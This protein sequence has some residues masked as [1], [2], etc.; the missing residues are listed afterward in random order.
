MA[1][2]P[3]GPFVRFVITTSAAV[4]ANWDTISGLFSRAVE[5]ATKPFWGYQLQNVFEMKDQT[6][7][8]SVRERGLYSM[9]LINTT[10]GDLDTTWIT[11]DFT[12]FESR[13]K[14]Q[15]NGMAGLIGTD[16]QLVEH[17]WYKFGP[18]IVAPNPPT[19]VTAVTGAVGTGTPVCPHQIATT[20]TLRTP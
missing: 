8:F 19:R 14:A 3:I 5:D 7:A 18:A 16:C 15:W 20:V 4:Y 6:G 13:V 2:V 1:A 17:R 11:S 9:H 10:G 12:D